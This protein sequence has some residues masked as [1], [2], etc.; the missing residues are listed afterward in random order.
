[1]QLLE[2]PEQI[3]HVEPQNLIF[4]KRSLS[5]ILSKTISKSLR[6]QTGLNE[7]FKGIPI[8]VIWM[9]LFFQCSRLQGIIAFSKSSIILLYAKHEYS[10]Y[11]LYYIFHFLVFLMISC[12]EFQTRKTTLIFGMCRNF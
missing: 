8:H 7:E 12:D 10:N 3:K 4:S 6:S 9:Q 5:K 11:L 2:N 1:M